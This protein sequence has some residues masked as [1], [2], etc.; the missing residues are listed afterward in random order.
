MSEVREFWD[1]V[2]EKSGIFFAGFV[3]ILPTL[4]VSPT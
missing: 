1:L 4:P 3:D 2:R